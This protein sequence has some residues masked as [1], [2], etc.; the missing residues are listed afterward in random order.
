MLNMQYIGVP[1]V[2]LQ[3]TMDDDQQRLKEIKN[4]RGI[5]LFK[6]MGYSFTNYSIFDI[7]DKPSVKG[8]SFVVSQAKLLTG[9]IFFNKIIHD[10]G[11]H[12]IYGKYRIPYFTYLY[13][14]ENR[15]NIEIDRLLHT[16]DYTKNSDKPSF[17]YAHFNMPHPPIFYDSAG[18]FLPLPVMFNDTSYTNKQLF[19]SYLKYANIKIESL[20]TDI[21]KKDPLSIVILMSDHGYRGYRSSA[22]D[23]PFQF[24]NICAVRFPDKNYLPVKEKWSNVNFLPYLFN[25][26]F[27]QKIPWLPDSSIFLRDIKLDMGQ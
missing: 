18:N 19:L 5:Q 16:I 22:I 26:E 25:A 3:N 27:N 15:N 20:L 1:F 8:N 6:S 13:M 2:P 24:N 4:A 11:W 23:Q 9:K 21:C 14:Q 12:F 17:I 10:L 7:L